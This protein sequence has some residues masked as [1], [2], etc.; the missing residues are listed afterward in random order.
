MLPKYFKNLHLAI[1]EINGTP[2][3]VNIDFDKTNRSDKYKDIDLKEWE[4]AILNWFSHFGIGKSFVQ[5]L[6]DY[7]FCVGGKAADKQ[8]L[9]NGLRELADKLE[10]MIK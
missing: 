5:V 2:R 9:I 6:T 7:T 1:S 10:E 8:S 4:S 3:I